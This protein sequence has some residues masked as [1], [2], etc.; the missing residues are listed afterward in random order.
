MASIGFAM[1]TSQGIM[2]WDEAYSAG[3]AIGGRWFQ[4]REFIVEVISISPKD[5][6]IVIRYNGK[7]IICQKLGQCH[8]ITDEIAEYYHK[9]QLL[10]DQYRDD[11][12]NN[13]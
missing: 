1:V 2:F 3:E 8:F 11:R 5:Q 10:K 6:T 9:I 4:Q 13:P 12:G 7:K